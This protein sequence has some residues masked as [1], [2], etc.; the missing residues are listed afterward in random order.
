MEDY[1]ENSI[2]L[3]HESCSI[4]TMDC[5]NIQVLAPTQ[6]RSVL[7][8]RTSL[9][10]CS[11]KWAWLI[12]SCDAIISAC[13][14]RFAGRFTGMA[15]VQGYLVDVFFARHVYKAILGM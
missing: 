1:L 3:F 5:L 4:L 13:R 9:M 12:S 2:S 14:F 11:G 7:I 6:Y 8:L 10:L 15:V